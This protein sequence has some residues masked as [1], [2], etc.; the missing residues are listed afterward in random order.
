MRLGICLFLTCA[1]AV[2]AAGGSSPAGPPDASPRVLDRS[3]SIVEVVSHDAED[4][5]SVPVSQPVSRRIVVR[6]ISASPI[7]VR[8]QSKSCGCLSPTVTPELVQPDGSCTLVF[9][10]AAAVTPNQ[11]KYTVV[12]RAVEEI[13]GASSHRMQ[14]II[15]GLRYTTDA[16]YLIR[17]S[18]LYLEVTQGE[19]AQAAVFLQS[20]M[21]EALRPR[22]ATSTIAG[23]SVVPDEAPV[24]EGINSVWPLRVRGT[25]ESLGLHRGLA[26]LTVEGAKNA[27]VDVP[28]VL[29]VSPRWRASPPGIVAD[30]RASGQS[31][32]RR[33]SLVD[34][35][36]GG[37]LA[38]VRFAGSSAGVT[39]KLETTAE[40]TYGLTVTIDVRAVPAPATD[41]LELFDED[42]RVVGLVPVVVYKPT[43]HR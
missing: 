5:G 6:N 33:V 26:R 29:R 36:S 1:V 22:E 31:I 16:Q 42:G 43:T 11:Q 10:V 40:G 9:G 34:S 20:L 27:E 18:R 41:T 35:Q 19:Q 23:L 37:R 30:L 25:P 3:A 14:D 24:Q 28:I 17:P 38:Q 12:F 8:V 13:E 32:T 15:A 4:K 7:R 21:K 39:A 2:L